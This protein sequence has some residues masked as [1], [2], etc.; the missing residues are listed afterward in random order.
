MRQPAVSTRTPPSEGPVAA[1]T[2]PV[3]AHSAVAVARFSAGNS[4]SISPSEVGTTIAAPTAWSTRAAITSSTLG[5]TAT[6]ADAARNAQRPT[7]NIF[8]RPT[9]SATLPAGTSSAANTMLYAFRIQDRSASDAS[10]NDRS[11]S[12]NAMLTIVASRNDMK[13]ATDV[14]S[15]IFHGRDIPGPPRL[16]VTMDRQDTSSRGIKGRHL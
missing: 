4:G 2:A 5:A 8:R 14:T 3:A 1:A 16:L 12:G 9:R 6:S 10:G 15:R 13:T 11:M 7:K